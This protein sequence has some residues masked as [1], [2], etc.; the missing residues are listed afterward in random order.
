MSS[1]A[2][3]ASNSSSA[4]SN[5]NNNNGTSGTQAA[6]SAAQTPSASAR[7]SKQMKKLVGRVLMPI[8]GCRSKRTNIIDQLLQNDE[9]FSVLKLDGSHTSLNLDR[10]V[11]AIK[12]NATVKNVQ[13]HGGYVAN[14]PM[15]QQHLLWHAI[16]DLVQLEEIHFKYFLEFPLMLDGLNC[17]LDR[18]KGLK[19]L[20]VYDSVMYTRNFEDRFV[21]LKEHKALKTVFF[22]QLR[23]PEGRALDDIIQSLLVA[24]NLA[25]LTIR[26]PRKK[27]NMVTDET[28]QLLT[29]SPSLKILELRRLV[30]KDEQI[31][32]IANDIDAKAE[33]GVSKMKEVTIQCDDCLREPCCQAIGNMLQKN[34]T[35]TRLEVWGQRVEED[36]FVYVINS[37]K[38]NKTLKVLHLSHD[39]GAKGNDALT[40][41]LKHNFV[42]ETLYMRSFGDP[43]MMARTDYFLKLNATNLRGLQLDI[44]MDRPKLV[45]KLEKHTDELNHL[46]FLLRGNPS[47]FG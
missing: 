30:L 1:A 33:A 37:L 23:I 10:L 24:P 18:A 41:L 4:T 46:Y 43:T 15:E 31:I 28:L 19:K 25:N 13:I 7:R 39:I 35:V 36:G 20:T 5:N 6:A 32:Q 8:R 17:L 3:V 9:E 16:G 44:N 2:S 29:A 42:M 11:D 34:T 27:K 26:I 14:L 38:D 22:S 12:A 45:E 40:E 21:D 47:V